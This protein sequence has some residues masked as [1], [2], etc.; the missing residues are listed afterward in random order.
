MTKKNG[1][2]TGRFFYLYQ[3]QRIMFKTLARINRLV[4]PSYSKQNLDLSKATAFQKLI[5]AWRYYITTR[6]LD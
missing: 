6:A 3:N 2:K 4:L 5:I 1:Q